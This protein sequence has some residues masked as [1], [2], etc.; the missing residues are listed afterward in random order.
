MMD[1][2]K[3]GGDRQELHERI[4]QL[5]I[6]AGH[7]VKD[8]GKPNDLIDRIAAEPMFGLTREE[9]E[10]HLE[11]KAYIGRCPEQVDEFLAGYVDPVLKR[12]AS[13]LEQQDTALTV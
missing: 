8:E 1:A 3:K 7:T 13:A 10:V 11:P 2:V 4:R 6:E 9:I 12:Y 5:S